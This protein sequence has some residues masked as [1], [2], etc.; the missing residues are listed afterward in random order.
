MQPVRRRLGPGIDKRHKILHHKALLACTVSAYTVS[1]GLT[2][3]VG[4][5]DICPSLAEHARHVDMALSRH[6]VKATAQG[7]ISS[8]WTSHHR[9]QT[10]VQLNM[11][12]YRCVSRACQELSS[13]WHKGHAV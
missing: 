3:L 9:S 4:H 13:S 6:V 8:S 7:E 12:D 5:V 2:F 1:E 11:L 10:A